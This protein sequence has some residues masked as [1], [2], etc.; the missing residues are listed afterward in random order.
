M[1]RA[2]STKGREEEWM[3]VLVEKL[4]EQIPPGRRRLR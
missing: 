3:Y 4:E 2:Y 1:G